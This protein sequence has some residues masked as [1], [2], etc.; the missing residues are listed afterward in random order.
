MSEYP[1]I[2]LDCFH[3]EVRNNYRTY[4]CIEKNI[5]LIKNYLPTPVSS[6]IKWIVFGNI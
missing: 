3:A 4:Q 2:R 1:F 5:Y 6:S